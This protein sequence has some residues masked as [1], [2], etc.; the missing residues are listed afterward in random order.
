MYLMSELDRNIFQSTLYAVGRLG[1]NREDEPAVETRQRGVKRVGVA[2]GALAVI[3]TIGG[4]TFHNIAESEKERKQFDSEVAKCVEELQHEDAPSSLP[5]PDYA[6]VTRP[7]G[8]EIFVDQETYCEA[9]TIYYNSKEE[10]K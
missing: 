10:P 4:Y 3:M 8:S 6:P 7:N 1:N 9:M 5:L 2:A